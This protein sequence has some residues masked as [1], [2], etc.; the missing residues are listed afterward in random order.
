M[1]RTIISKVNYVLKEQKALEVINYI[2]IVD[3]GEGN[4][5]EN[6]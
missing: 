6:R 2:N 3:P 1:A 5:T 4:S